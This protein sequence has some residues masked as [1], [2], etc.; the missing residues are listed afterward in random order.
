MVDTNEAAGPDPSPGPVVSRL[1]SLAGRS[2]TGPCGVSCTEVPSVG[3][4]FTKRR[5]VAG[6][7]RD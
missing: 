5:T 4:P 3:I 6:L 7:G 1:P 2:P